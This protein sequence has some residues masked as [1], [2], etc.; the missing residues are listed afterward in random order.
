MTHVIQPN[1][2]IS[3]NLPRPWQHPRLSN[4]LCELFVTFSF[5]FFYFELIFKYF[6]YYSAQG[7]KR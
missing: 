7:Q 4:Q 1:T 6:F 3:A 5:L 2:N